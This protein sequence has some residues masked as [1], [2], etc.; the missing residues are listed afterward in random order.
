MLT[1]WWL[2]T[3]AYWE[4]PKRT[5]MIFSVAMSTT[6]VVAVKKGNKKLLD[7]VNRFIISYKK[8]GGFTKLANKY[9][10]SEMSTFKKLNVP[11]M[12]E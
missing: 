12:F 2:D 6:E 10:A 7:E 5:K 1:F 8:S 9:L 4:T 3:L 11:F